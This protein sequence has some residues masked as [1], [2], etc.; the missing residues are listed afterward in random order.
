MVNREGVFNTTSS[1]SITRNVVVNK[2]M[3]ATPYAKTAGLGKT[4]LSVYM[5]PI[6]SKKPV[7]T[8]N[9]KSNLVV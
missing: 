2:F 7:N 8:V 1:N 4:D 3:P 5:T 9:G 6:K